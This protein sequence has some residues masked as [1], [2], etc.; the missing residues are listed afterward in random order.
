[1]KVGFFFLFFIK[2]FHPPTIYL[3]TLPKRLSLQLLQLLLLLLLQ[4]KNVH[5]PYL[6]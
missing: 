2:A 1:M 5:L 6:T 4:Q 3:P